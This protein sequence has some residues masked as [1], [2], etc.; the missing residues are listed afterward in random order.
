MTT[1]LEIRGL[2]KAFGG[3]R[4][5]RIQ[6]LVVSAGDALAID[7]I[8]APAAEVLLHLVTGA[9]VPDE[10]SVRTFSRDTRE[11]TE[12]QAWLRSLDALG[13]LS[14]RAPL[15]DPLTV[16]QNLAI[17]LTLDVDPIPEDARQQVRALAAR[18]GL[19]DASLTGPLGASSHM[20]RARVRLARAVALR[21]MLVVAEHPSTD[22]SREESAAL[23]TSLGQMS[24]D[25]G[26]AILAISADR[27]FADALGGRQLRLN[28]ATGELLE[29][30]GLV[31]RLSRLFR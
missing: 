27:R 15:I 17:P 19:D 21:P 14:S 9:A 1:L 26:F 3:L 5:L 8:D 6:E 16:E 2:V 7:G 31:N 30:A 24:R 29:A 13:V 22:L 25:A 28:A 4:P 11:I 12:V 10:G 18:V 20:V 23:G